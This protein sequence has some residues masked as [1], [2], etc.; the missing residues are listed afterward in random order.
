[1]PT[2]DELRQ[3]L[4]YA[5][6]PA[7]PDTAGIIARGRCQRRLRRALTASAAAAVALVA[8]AG[9]ALV[10]A[11]PRDAPAGNPPPGDNPP[12]RLE[13]D[14]PPARLAGAAPNPVL[15][16]A[17]TSVPPTEAPARFDPLRRT[18]HV[19][20]IPDGLP[21]EVG[22]IEAYF[23]LYSASTADET[24]GMVVIVL[25]KG[26]PLTAMPSGQRFMPRYTSNATFV[27]TEP[28]NGRDAQCVRDPRPLATGLP[29]SNAVPR[30]TASCPTIQWQYAPDAWARASY[31]APAGTTVEQANAQIRELAESVSLAA[32]D[33]VRLPFTISGGRPGQ[34]IA[35][36]L[37]STGGGRSG[38]WY[39]GVSFVDTPADLERTLFTGPQ[40]NVEAYRVDPNG[41]PGHLALSP[42][43]STVDGHPAWRP[44]DG[45]SVLVFLEPDLRVMFEY[46][47][48]PG[49]ATTAVSTV[50]LTPTPDAVATWVPLG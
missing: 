7:Q 16:A 50:H 1:M 15:V 40:I 21:R 6:A 23:Q 18:L 45:R 32:D 19:G 22:E 9:V 35:R 10:G 34:V 14:N 4:N 29:T 47:E 24:A 42:P 36:T 48:R 2:I 13:G 49:D 33:P 12:S 39:G 3:A 41:D 25:P 44:D 43:N 5:S 11:G 30:P 17:F 26:R 20:W 46:F 37:V 31:A 38:L 8:V 27:D 28:I